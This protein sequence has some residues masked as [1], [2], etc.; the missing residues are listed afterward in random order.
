MLSMINEGNLCAAITALLLW[1][2]AYLS[3]RGVFNHPVHDLIIWNMA[4]LALRTL[5]H[6]MVFGCALRIR[7]CPYGRVAV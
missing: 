5:S 1:R 6:R 7:F 3:P 4:V 2:K